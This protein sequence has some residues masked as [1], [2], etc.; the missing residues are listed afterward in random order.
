MLCKKSYIKKHT[1]IINYL[2][3]NIENIGKEDV[4]HIDKNKFAYLLHLVE[5]NTSQEWL[6]TKVFIHILTLRSY[7]KK[8]LCINF[9]KV[10][11]F[12]NCKFG[13]IEV[14]YF[15]MICFPSMFTV[16]G[17]PRNLISDNTSSPISL[18]Q[19][20]TKSLAV[21]SNLEK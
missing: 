1:K 17:T 11:F 13:K 6:S 21:V 20:S 18:V 7:Q 12:L 9:R 2:L 5:I 8:N 19:K 3:S 14:S 4:N 15:K 16:D 10:T